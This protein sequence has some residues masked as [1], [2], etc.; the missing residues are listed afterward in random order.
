MQ[1]DWIDMQKCDSNYVHE[2]LK[3]LKLHQRRTHKIIAL[4]KISSIVNDT[5]L[6]DE[7]IDSVS[8]DR[9]F[10]D[11]QKEEN[12]IAFNKNLNYLKKEDRNSLQH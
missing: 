6:N 9:C 7:N 3:S 10:P 2:S 11:L 8:N 1:K 12:W 4:N 5:T